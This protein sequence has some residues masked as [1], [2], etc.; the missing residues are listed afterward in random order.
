MMIITKKPK[1]LKIQISESIK[2]PQLEFQD[3]NLDT[4]TN[5]I[6]PT[7]RETH[8]IQTIY[9]QALYLLK[10]MEFQPIT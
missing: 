5:T 10:T 2:K 1:I 7:I 3:I 8:E 4:L 9:V 6:L